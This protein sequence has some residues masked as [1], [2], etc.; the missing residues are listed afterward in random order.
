MKRGIGAD[1]KFGYHINVIP[2]KAGMTLIMALTAIF[3][4]GML[5]CSPSL[6]QPK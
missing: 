4:I 5:E 1:N 2:A 3:I 6:R